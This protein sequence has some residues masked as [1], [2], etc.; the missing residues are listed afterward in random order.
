MVDVVRR[1]KL[2]GINAVRLPFS[3]QDLYKAVPRDFHWQYCTNVDG[4]TFVQSVTNP[5]VPPPAGARPKS[6][7]ILKISQPVYL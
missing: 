7:L 5:G 4:P 6:C 1:M 3:F 2:L